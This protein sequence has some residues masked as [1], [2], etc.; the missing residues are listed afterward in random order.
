MV[1]EFNFLNIFVNFLIVIKLKGNQ[2][3]YYSHRKHEGSESS[4][5]D[6]T[7]KTISSSSS[8]SIAEGRKP[9]TLLPRSLPLSQSIEPPSSSSIF[10]TGKPRDVNRP[11]IKQLEE[12]LEQSLVLSRQ[13][14]AAAAAAAAAD[15]E[16]ASGSP[17][18]ERLRTTST[19]SSNNSNR[20]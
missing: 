6:E 2:N 19:T 4:N 17:S 3:G 13:Q 7:N 18:N 20:K 14:A 10:G 8:S 5:P 1:I 11:E 16:T 15:A 9:L 12:R